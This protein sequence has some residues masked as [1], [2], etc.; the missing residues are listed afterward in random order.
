MVLSKLVGKK[1][2]GARRLGPTLIDDKRKEVVFIKEGPANVAE[3]L[4]AHAIRHGWTMTGEYTVLASDGTEITGSANVAEATMAIDDA[5][6][7]KETKADIVRAIESGSE[8]WRAVVEHEL[9][10][11]L[12]GFAYDEET[13]E[14]V[15]GELRMS[16]A[17]AVIFNLN[18]GCERMLAGSIKAS[19][20]ITEVGVMASLSMT[21]ATSLLSSE[22][23]VL[24]ANDVFD[25]VHKS[26][27]ALVSQGVITEEQAKEHREALPANP[28]DQIKGMTRIIAKGLGDADDPDSLFESLEEN[29][30]LA[31][32]FNPKGS[33]KE[34]K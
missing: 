25:K 22:K 20:D 2:K 11:P 17:L 33:D 21:L 5:S 34:E 26:I 3:L 24:F 7:S 18:Q 32:R 4:I 8:K 13:G 15:T 10:R 1:T 30:G 23:Y 19:S 16:G 6:L 14:A 27:D 12:L 9:V 29:T 28:R 31:E